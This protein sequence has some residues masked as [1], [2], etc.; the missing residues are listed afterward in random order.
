MAA[1]SWIKRQGKD[2]VFVLLS[3]RDRGK[4]AERGREKGGNGEGGRD[5]AHY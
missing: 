2:L 4:E 3:E 1:N 5:R